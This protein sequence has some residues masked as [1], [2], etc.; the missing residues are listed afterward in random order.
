MSTTISPS[1]PEVVTENAK[2]KRKSNRKPLY[3]L[4]EGTKL[5]VTPDDFDPEKNRLTKAQFEDQ[6]CYMEHQA[7][8]HERK[9]KSLRELAAE[10]RINPP[11]RKASQKRAKLQARL[12]AL[13]NKLKELGVDP[14]S[15]FDD[16]EESEAAPATS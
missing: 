10:Y 2:A 11:K 6:P 9:A 13:E 16:S 14:A 8:M 7:L 15:L 4:P 3:E 1:A 5:T 12:V